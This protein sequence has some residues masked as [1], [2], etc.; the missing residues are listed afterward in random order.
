MATIQITA[1][2]IDV[3]LLDDSL[4]DGLVRSTISL[5][6]A[7]LQNER[8]LESI[9]PICRQGFP[10]NIG[11]KLVP[12]DRIGSSQGLSGS[13]VMVSYLFDRA[14]DNPLFASRPLIVK[15]ASPEDGGTDTLRLEKSNAEEI[16]DFAAYHPDSF[17]IPL[18]INDARSNGSVSVLWSP[19]AAPWKVS[20]PSRLVFDA[21]REFLHLLRQEPVTS[22]ETNIYNV[23]EN[24]Y[25]LLKPLHQRGGRSKAESH[26]FI[27][28]YTDYLRGIVKS[29]KWVE[30]WLK[31][32]GG[33]ESRRVNTFN[34]EWINPFWLLNQIKDQSAQMYCGA[35]HGDLH[36]RNVIMG[37]FG[38]PR[39]IDFGWASG[40]AHIAKDFVLMEANLRFMLLPPEISPENLDKM[41][42]I[43]AFTE[44]PPVLDHS[45]CNER[46]R[47]IWALRDIAR[48]HFPPT[49][50]WFDEYIIPLFLTSLG[51][52]K[53]IRSAD[54]T[55]AAQLTILHLATYIGETRGL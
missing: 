2:N 7:M 24:L 17:A 16:T 44:T 4:K 31:E 6:E 49:T 27:E 18:H 39:I 33:L 26:T 32:W 20:Y 50:D 48:R 11:L 22:R 14:S 12:L 52:L 42:Q 30:I 37:T 36:P 10:S 29:A 23:L 54:N 9:W 47:V 25:E 19:F 53:H 34:K 46:I 41:T 55:A 28:E 13:K 15:I 38:S 40:S 51:L 8:L 43:V 21:Q 3:E 1:E 5:L 45:A 35:V